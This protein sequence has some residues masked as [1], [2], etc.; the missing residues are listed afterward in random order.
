MTW[1]PG[2]D[3][4]DNAGF[5]SHFWFWV[6]IVCLFAVGASA[7]ISHIYGLRKDELMSDKMASLAARQT[8]EVEALQN[9]LKEVGALQNKLEQGNTSVPEPPTAMRTKILTPEQQQTL[10]AALSPFVGQKVRVDT[11][12]GS[13]DG[14]A[15]DFVEVFR[16]AKWH[17]DA[18]SPSQVVPAKSLFGLQPTIN[19]IS[20]VPPGFSVLVDTLAAL[21]LGPKTGFADEQ[22]PVGTIALKIGIGIIR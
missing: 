18:G 10:I 7:V 2:W 16:A 9:K 22:T 19:R 15:N 6:A 21:G 17:V 20:P 12:V 11:V 13:D 3:S 1:W 5:W 4:V 8:A 14:L